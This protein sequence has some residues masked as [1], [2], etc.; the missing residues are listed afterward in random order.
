MARISLSLVLLLGAA[1]GDETSPDLVMDDSGLALVTSGEPWGRMELDFDD[2]VEAHVRSLC[3][4]PLS[5]GCRVVRALDKSDDGHADEPPA[6]PDEMPRWISLPTDNGGSEAVDVD[7]W[8]RDVGLPGVGGGRVVLPVDLSAHRDIVNGAESIDNV[9]AYVE[10]A[11]HNLSARALGLSVVPGLLA[12]SANPDGLIAGHQ[13][14]R[15]GSLSLPASGMS[16]RVELPF[17]ARGRRA[18]VDAVESAT[19]TAVLSIERG[20]DAALPNGS[21]DELRARPSGSL[22]VELLFDATISASSLSSIGALP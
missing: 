20:L 17:G 16:G 11:H 6:L 13:P 9:A 8:A 21:S 14:R 18:F 1:C 22:V 10:K 19:F 12:S 3:R 7:A 2:I 4:A 15:V 5:H